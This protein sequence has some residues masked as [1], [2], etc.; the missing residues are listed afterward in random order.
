[1][2]RYDLTEPKK[3]VGLIIGALIILVIAAWLIWNAMERSDDGQDNIIQEI[4]LPS[5]EAMP[6]SESASAGAVEEADPASLAAGPETESEVAEE[7]LVLPSLKDSDDFFRDQISNLSADFSSLLGS[8][9]LIRKYLVIVNDFSQRQ[10]S[11]KH[12]RFL[13][14]PEPFSVEAGQ[15]GLYMGQRSYQRYDRLAQAFAA[16]DNDLAIKI[17]QRLYQLMQEVF[18][19]FGYPD[20]YRLEDLFQK[21]A[22]E[23]IAAPVIEGR[24]KLVKPSVRY[25]FADKKLE[26]LSPVQKQMLRM[27]PQNTRI[28]QTKL[29]E[30]L[31]RLV[32]LN[33]A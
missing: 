25:K 10:R 16:I 29:R 12:M 15:Q 22:A 5:Q 2:G 18:A 31:Q 28:I 11:H 19:G 17:Y 32:Q 21:A 6:V 4:S 1:M 33:K 9:Q 26:S 27:G 8:E 13:R 7:P 20:E 14:L 30:L 23:I 3:P 24:I